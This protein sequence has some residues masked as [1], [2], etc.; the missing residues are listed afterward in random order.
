MAKKNLHKV[1]HDTAYPLKFSKNMY[2]QRCIFCC[3]EKD[4]GDTGVKNEVIL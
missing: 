1:L 3:M 2:F 4:C